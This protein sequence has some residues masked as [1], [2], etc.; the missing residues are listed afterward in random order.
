MLL[1]LIRE[2]ESQAAA[3]EQQISLS[4]AQVTSKQREIR[5]L[6]LTLEELSGVSQKTP[7]YE[8]V[9]KMFAHLFFISVPCFLLLTF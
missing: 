6:K 2:I 4:R 7:T 9:G 1:Q 3:A 8:G 5:L